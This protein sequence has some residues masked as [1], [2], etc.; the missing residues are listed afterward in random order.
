MKKLFRTLNKFSLT[1]LAVFI[2]VILITATV[3]D[4]NNP[5]WCVITLSFIL[6]VFSI[7]GDTFSNAYMK[8]SKYKVLWKRLL[9]NVNPG[10]GGV[11]EYIWWEMKRMEDDDN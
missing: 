9:S 8:V 5:I 2:S 3:L 7:V 1:T 11:D 6:I 10:K 4:V